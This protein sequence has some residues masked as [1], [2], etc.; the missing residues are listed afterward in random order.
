MSLLWIFFRPLLF[1]ID[2][3]KAHR[4]IVHLLVCFTRLRFRSRVQIN[5]LPMARPTHQSLFPHFSSGLGLAAGFDKDG[6]LIRIL[7]SFGFGFMEL[8]TVTPL[9]QPGNPLP[10]LFRDYKQ[11]ALRNQ[12]GFNNCGSLEAAERLKKARPDLPKGFGV[13][14]NIGKNK[15]TSLDMAWQDYQKA[16]SPFKGLV[17]YVVVNVSSPNTPGLRDLQS[18]QYLKA[19]LDAVN[20]EMAAWPLSVPVLIKLA[21]ELSLDSL[22]EVVDL[23]HAMKLGGLVLTNTLKDK[24]G[25]PGGWSGSPLTLPALDALQKVRP[26]TSL[27]IIS[28][29]GI[30]NCKDAETRLAAGANL[31]QIYTGWVYGGPSFPRQI[32]AAWKKK[33]DSKHKKTSSRA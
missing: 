7:P 23:A 2:P 20:S 25:L 10:R 21:P 9:P 28:V 24:G 16:V 19:I 17:D 29:G 14:I 26:L 12:M 6:E 30:M 11:T 8:G 31:L 5:E 33:H 32:L 18:T 4:F 22:K 1:C 15:D 27:P 3:E 13:G